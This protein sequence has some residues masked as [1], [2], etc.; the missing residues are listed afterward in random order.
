MRPSAF[1]TSS[2]R[3]QHLS[4]QRVENLKFQLEEYAHVHRL[5]GLCL[6]GREGVNLTVSSESESGREEF[7]SELK[8]WLGGIALSFRDATARKHPFRVFKVKIKDEIVTLGRPGWIP[9]AKTERHLSPEAWHEALHAPDTVVIDTRNDYE[10]A[11]GKFKNAVDLKLSEFREFPQA[12]RQS[13]IDK[14]KKVLIYCTGGI[15]CEKAILEMQDQGFE[16]VYQLDGGILNYLSQYPQAEFEGECFVFDYRVA[17]DQTLQ[18]TTHY[19]LCPHCG[20][21]A[22]RPLEC[23]KCG[24][25]AV[26]CQRCQE[27]AVHACSKNCAHHARIGSRSRKPHLPELRQKQGVKRPV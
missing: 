3:F 22:N 6:V 5:R 12:L 19:R 20:H 18:P 7:K 26:I 4:D 14:N 17:V 13:G 11:I 10:V 16:Q 27:S 1:I 8:Q 25:H 23:M 9:E 24:S 21:P 2:Y 15:R